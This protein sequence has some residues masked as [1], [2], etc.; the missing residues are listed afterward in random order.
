MPNAELVP[1]P[2]FS[3]YRA[4]NS[5][6]DLFGLYDGSEVIAWARGAKQTGKMSRFPAAVRNAFE[7]FLAKEGREFRRFI[8]VP[9]PAYREGHDE[10]NALIDR[11]IASDHQPSL[12]ALVASIQVD[13]DWMAL[14]G[15]TG[16]TQ[17]ARVQHRLRTALERVVA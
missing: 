8:D 1:L 9:N 15:D 11:V 12:Q 3:D 16:T 2:E 7:D 6:R 14:F 17:D 10:L 5:M 13:L 4:T